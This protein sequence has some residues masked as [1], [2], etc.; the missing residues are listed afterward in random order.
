MRN[1]S[2]TNNAES[3]SRQSLTPLRRGTYHAPSEV[4]WCPVPGA[5]DVRGQTTLAQAAAIIASCRCYV[6]IDSGLMWIAGSLRVSAVGLYGTTYIPAYSAIQPVNPRAI[7]LVAEGTLDGI[8]PER[9]L[10][11]YR[12]AA[13]EPA[14]AVPSGS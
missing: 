2:N 11:A 8:P 12:H 1:G 6:G 14:A 9:A 7:Y 3:S 13:A 10:L 5:F 4:G